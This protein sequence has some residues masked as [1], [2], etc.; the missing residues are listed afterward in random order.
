[1]L[2]IKFQ[3]PDVIKQKQSFSQHCQL[4][5]GTAVA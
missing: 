2:V 4:L 1:M 3:M 5:D